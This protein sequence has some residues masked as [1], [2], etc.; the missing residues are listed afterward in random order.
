MSKQ[1]HRNYQ[2]LTGSVV[3]NLFVP[4]DTFGS[5]WEIDGHQAI[6]P[7][8][9]LWWAKCCR[10]QNLPSCSLALLRAEQTTWWTTGSVWLCGHTYPRWVPKSLN[11]HHQTQKHH[12]GDSLVGMIQSEAP[13]NHILKRIKCMHKWAPLKPMWFDI[14]LAGWCPIFYFFK[15]DYSV[16]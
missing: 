12:H 13:L 10:C 7:I 1:L 2:A 4:T 3:P 14:Y 6:W 8:F 11:R 15:N 5:L 9:S 16:I